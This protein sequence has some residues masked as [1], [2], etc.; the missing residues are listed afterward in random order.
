MHFFVHYHICNKFTNFQSIMHFCTHIYNFMFFISRGIMDLKLWHRKEDTI[1]K[2]LLSTTAIRISW[3]DHVKN[4]HRSSVGN[5][6]FSK[7]SFDL[8]RGKFALAFH[9]L[10]WSSTNLILNVPKIE[11]DRDGHHRLMMSM[12]GQSGDHSKI[13]TERTEIG[14]NGC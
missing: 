13:A 8:L 3:V 4:K 2:K 1:C 12:S 7:P 5:F 10:S 14:R 11:E 6:F 9:I